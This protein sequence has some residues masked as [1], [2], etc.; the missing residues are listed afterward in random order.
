MSIIAANQ[1]SHITT[2]EYTVELD[3]LKNMIVADLKVDPRTVELIWD[4]DP[5]FDD[6]HH[7]YQAPKLRGLK[8]KVVV[9]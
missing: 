1:T 9:R 7:G 3:V 4:I 5:G 6:G 8:I 2:T